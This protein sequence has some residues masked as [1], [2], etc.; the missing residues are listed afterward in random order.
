MALSVDLSI[1]PF[2]YV[3]VHLSHSIL[4][5]TP[6]RRHLNSI[7]EFVN[8]ALSLTQI[9]VLY[10]SSNA[11]GPFEK[12]SLQ[13]FAASYHNL[14]P[15][16]KMSKMHYIT[17]AKYITKQYRAMYGISN[18]FVCATCHFRVFVINAIERGVEVTWFLL[19]N[20]KS[21]VSPLTILLKIWLVHVCLSINSRHVARVDLICIVCTFRYYK[22]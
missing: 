21:S 6:I 16:E 18:R 2:T 3:F 9:T 4:T 19:T 5:V 12:V 17:L 1:S 22:R 8:D 10:L 11:V 20:L 7:L 15:L 14:Q 13:E